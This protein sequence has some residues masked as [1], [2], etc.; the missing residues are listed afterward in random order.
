VA[1]GPTPTSERLI[2]SGSTTHFNQGE[3]KMMDSQAEKVEIERM[4]DRVEA[5]ENRHDVDAMLEEMIDDPLLHLCGFPPV[6]GQDAVRQLYHGFFQTFVSTRITSQRIQVSASGDMAWDC[7]AYVNEYEGP[8]G[9]TTEEGKYLG[10]YHKVDGRW[11]GAV[12]C[13]TPNG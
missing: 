1:K 8:A 13:I 12:F 7:G 10:V 3:E 4:I 6:Q 11:K 9:R 5:A 2:G